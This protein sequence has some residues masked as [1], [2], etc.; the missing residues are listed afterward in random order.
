[1]SRRTDTELADA[2][3]HAHGSLRL[4]AALVELV[5]RRAADLSDVD[6]AALGTVVA[7][8]EN[9]VFANKDSED[10]WFKAQR[11]LQRIIAAHRRGA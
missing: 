11:V 5:E 7:F 8:A 9:A 3:G 10:A 2:F 4:T 6:I 1:V